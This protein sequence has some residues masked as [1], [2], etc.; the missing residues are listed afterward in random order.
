MITDAKRNKI[1]F[2]SLAH[3]VQLSVKFAK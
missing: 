1:N 3:D 2:I